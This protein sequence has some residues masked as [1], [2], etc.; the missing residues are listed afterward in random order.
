[1]GRSTSIMAVI[2]RHLGPPD[3][4]LLTCVQGFLR[5]SWLFHSSPAAH[6]RECQLLCQ[7]PVFAQVRAMVASPGPLSCR[8]HPSGTAAPV[9][10][11]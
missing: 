5:T 1:M 8:G 10:P 2:G 9:Y 11:P 7:W 6:S 4:R 3:E